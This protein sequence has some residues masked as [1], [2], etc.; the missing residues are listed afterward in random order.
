MALSEVDR[1]T[2][3]IYPQENTGSYNEY[4]SNYAPPVPRRERL[5]VAAKRL[6]KTGERAVSG[7]R[8]ATAPALQKA[9]DHIFTVAAITCFDWAAFLWND[10][11][12][13]ITAGVAFV[14]F[15]LK[16]SKS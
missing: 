6:W 13:L 2:R 1:L 11:A 15:E 8:V 10:K 5:R 7:L 12:G 14:L 9:Q 4:E 3:R 16:V